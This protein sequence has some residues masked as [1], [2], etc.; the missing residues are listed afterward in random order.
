[1]F[2]RQWN[3]LSERI[4]FQ[5]YVEFSYRLLLYKITVDNTDDEEDDN[6]D[7]MSINSDSSDLSE[8]SCNTLARVCISETQFVFRKTRD[9]GLFIYKHFEDPNIQ[10]DT[11]PPL[12]SDMSESECINKFHFEKNKL[13]SYPKSYGI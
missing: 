12:I 1:M 7:H 13:K 10:W 6:D 9:Y 5:K 11:P 3:T 8:S 2:L 4:C